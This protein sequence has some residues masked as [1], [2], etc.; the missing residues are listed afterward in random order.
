VKKAAWLG[1]IDPWPGCFLVIA[2]KKPGD[3]ISFA[4]NCIKNWSDCINYLRYL[5]ILCPGC[6]VGALLC[7][8][9][10]VYASINTIYASIRA[11]YASQNAGYQSIT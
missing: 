8:C 10:C 7:P 11:G 1:V 5:K 3:C 9:G 2:S 4:G 6:D